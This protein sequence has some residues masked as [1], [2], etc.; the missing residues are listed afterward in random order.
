MSTD[1]KRCRWG[2]EER[3]KNIGRKR[4][5]ECDE[6]RKVFPENPDLKR[7]D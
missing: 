4:E 2:E 1:D 7:N 6:K 3:E 5:R